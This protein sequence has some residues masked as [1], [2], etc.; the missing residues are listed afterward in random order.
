MKMGGM[1]R[2]SCLEMI[3]VLVSFVVAIPCVLI[4]LNSFKTSADAA[5]LNLL[6]PN[7]WNIWHNYSFVFK[8]A[9]LASAFYNTTLVT[10]TSVI[11][12]IILSSTAAFVIQRRNNAFTRMLRI[13]LILGLI[14]PISIITTYI[15]MDAL[16]L[17]D[18]Y[19][20]IILLYIATNFAFITYLYISFFDSV[21]REIDEAANID[22]AEGL[23]MFFRVIYPLLKPINA[24]AFILSFL[25]IWNDFN[26][27][28]FFLNSPTRSTLTLTIFA[29]FG[30]HSADWNYVFA[31][32]IMISLPVIIAYIV[33]Q[34]QIVSGLTAGAVKS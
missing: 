21:P 4:L 32:L 10:T 31:D 28:L 7:K 17:T 27:S 33:V 23:S 34:K 8:E 22:G 14:L 26:L 24:T 3:A 12:I 18:N 16:Y 5:D 2:K 13:V 30:Q 29:F 1:I 20:G 9:H 25:T 11:G 15:F 19:I 6:F